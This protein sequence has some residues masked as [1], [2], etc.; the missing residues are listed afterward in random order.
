MPGELLYALPAMAVLA[1]AIV[2]VLH[3]TRGGES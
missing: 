2:Y 3:A 1:G